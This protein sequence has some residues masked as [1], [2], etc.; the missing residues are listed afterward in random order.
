[1]TTTHWL[2]DRSGSGSVLGPATEPTREAR[3]K[4]TET[5]SIGELVLAADVAN[6]LASEARREG[7]T[8]EALIERRL[9]SAGVQ[10]AQIR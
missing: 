6:R 1:M 8:L 9:H 4:A 10:R 5:I 7:T 3:R 2:W